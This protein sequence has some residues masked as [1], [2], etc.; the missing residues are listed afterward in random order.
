MQSI[1]ITGRLGRDAKIYKNTSNGNEFITFSLA[2]NSRIKK[3]EEK[4][5]WYDI[6][7]PNYGVNRYRNVVPYL[8]KGCAV[9][10]QGELDADL[11]KGNDGVYRNRL[12]VSAT[13]VDFNSTGNQNSDGKHNATTSAVVQE[14]TPKQAEQEIQVVSKKAPAAASPQ[15]ATYDDSDD[16]LPF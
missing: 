5:T 6:V 15:P 2:T 12:T 7:I 16:D 3:N 10:V 1:T 14:A 4:T 13:F 11:E 8:K 9:V